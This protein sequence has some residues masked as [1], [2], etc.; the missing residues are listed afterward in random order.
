MPNRIAKS[1]VAPKDPVKKT[2]SKKSSRKSANAEPGYKIAAE[3]G[4]NTEN[5]QENP[6]IANLS[7][8]KYFTL[9]K[10]TSNPKE[11]RTKPL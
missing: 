11:G 4:Y 8:P 2:V 5:P 1:K 7:V 10:G 6:H 9:E 3:A